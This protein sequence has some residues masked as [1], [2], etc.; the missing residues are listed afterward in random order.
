MRYR[1]SRATNGE[2]DKAVRTTIT[3]PSELHVWLRQYA[4]RNRTTF[5]RLSAD[6]MEQWAREHGYVSSPSTQKMPD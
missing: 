4:L 6:I 3:L 2:E 5:T 1:D